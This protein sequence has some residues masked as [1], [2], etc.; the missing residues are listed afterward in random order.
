MYIIYRLLT[1]VFCAVVYI[2]AERV[3]FSLETSDSQEVHKTFHVLIAAEY[4]FW[5]HVH[6]AESAM[7][8]RE[9]WR[10]FSMCLALC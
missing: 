1:A 3:A 2:Y 9:I 6:F 5:S 10:G 8:Y 7:R 4:F